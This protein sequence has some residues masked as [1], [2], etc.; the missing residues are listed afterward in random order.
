MSQGRALFGRVRIEVQKIIVR[1]VTVAVHATL[2]IGRR[3]AADCRQDVH[4]DVANTKQ[5]SGKK[6]ARDTGVPTC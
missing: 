6:T 5:A 2:V 3:I 1:P 4:R